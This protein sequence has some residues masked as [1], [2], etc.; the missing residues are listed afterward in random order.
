[1]WVFA[2]A[3]FP[4]FFV[5][6]LEKIMP[7]FNKWRELGNK[8]FFYI[9]KMGKRGATNTYYKLGQQNSNHTFN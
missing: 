2:S 4:R 9:P 5:L 6:I 1:M 7:A 8:I 3:Y